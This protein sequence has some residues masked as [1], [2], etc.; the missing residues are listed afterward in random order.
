MLRNTFRVPGALAPLDEITPAPM[1]FDISNSTDSAKN[2][3]ISELIERNN[4]M[5]AELIALR[6]QATSSSAPRDLK[7][8]KVNRLSMNADQHWAEASTIYP[9]AWLSTLR[10]FKVEHETTKGKL[11]DLTRQLALSESTSS[12]YESNASEAK[13]FT[14][15][16]MTRTIDAE[17]VVISQI[18]RIDKT[19][20]L[21]RA[22]TRTLVEKLTALN[23]SL[24]E[25]AM[26]TIKAEAEVEALKAGLATLQSASDFAEFNLDQ[27]N[28]SNVMLSDRLDSKIKLIE[29]QTQSLK[30]SDVELRKL[31]LAVGDLN[32]ENEILSGK[33]VQLEKKPSLNEGSQTDE[34]ITTDAYAETESLSAAEIQT[35]SLN[36]PVIRENDFPTKG[37]NEIIIF[38]YQKQLTYLVK[39][40]KPLSL[41]RILPSLVNRMLL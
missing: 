7:A 34:P 24:V 35:H 19:L 22:E 37:L 27:V 36:I 6:N 33:I 26:Y 23:Q 11:L 5:G 41:K 20:S 14:D 40:M 10:A 8:K 29:A 4:W 21:S 15:L 25:Q 30:Q 39:P 9:D 17:S 3:I 2:H 16:L 31:K 1:M 12:I 13:A 18:K 28:S 32:L 38:L